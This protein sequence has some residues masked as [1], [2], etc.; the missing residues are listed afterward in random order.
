MELSLFTLSKPK[1]SGENV[2]LCQNLGLKN[3]F[4]KVQNLFG[5]TNRTLNL[6]LKFGTKKVRLVRDRIRYATFF[7]SYPISTRDSHISQRATGLR[8]DMGRGLIRG[9]IRKMSYHNLSIIYFLLLLFCLVEVVISLSLIARW[10]H[11]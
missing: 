9:M 11:E 7:V 5:R 3:C 1:M 2:G 8:A 4:K 10:C 6:T